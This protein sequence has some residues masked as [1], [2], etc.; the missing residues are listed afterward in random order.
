MSEELLEPLKKAINRFVSINWK[1]RTQTY[2]TVLSSYQ[3]MRDAIYHCELNGFAREKLLD[4]LK[5]VRE[6]H[7]R[8]PFMKRLQQW[9]RGYP[10]DFETIEYLYQNENKAPKETVENI[11][12]DYALNSPISQQHRNKIH[13]QAQYI[14]ESI[15]K[16]KS[17]K[18][19]SLAAAGCIDIR[20]TVSH[21]KE[22]SAQLVI[23][24]IDKDAL[25]FYQDRLNEIK[26]TC[27]YFNDNPISILKKVRSLGPFDLILIGGLFD[28][29]SDKQIILIL[30]NIY[31]SLLKNGGKIFFTNIDRG[32]PYRIWMEYFVNWMLIERDYGKICELVNGATGSSHSSNFSITKDQTGLTHFVTILK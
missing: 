2:A 14:I 22:S 10:G 8:S 21:I 17:A 7:G 6:I 15:D 20:I 27:F 12:E 1:H 19:L 31:A 26:N 4:I 9:P 23:N 18:I 5:P 16:N 24:D 11:C 28:Y 30:R 13:Q 32:N 25:G 3:E 29:L